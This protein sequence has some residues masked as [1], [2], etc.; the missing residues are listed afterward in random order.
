MSG[1]PPSAVKNR[2]L[3]PDVSESDAHKMVATSMVQFVDQIIGGHASSINIGA[4]K[5]IV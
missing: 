2:D 5:T 1:V 4:S 3:K